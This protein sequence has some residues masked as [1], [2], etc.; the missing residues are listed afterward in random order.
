M[1]ATLG[2][3][4]GCL[5]I[6]SPRFASADTVEKCADASEQADRLAAEHKP[7]AA[8]KALEA[9]VVPECPTAVRQYC[10]QA[11]EN[12]A[13]LVPSVIAAARD[14]A[15]RD[16][17]AVKLL[18]DGAAASLGTSIELEPG[19]HVFRF[20][21]AGFRAKEER[22]NLRE[23]ER[24][25]L[26][27]VVLETTEAPRSTPSA[28]RP[29]QTRESEASVSPLAYVFAGVA[30]VAAGAGTVLGV[31]GQ[32]QFDRCGSDGCTSSEWDDVDRLRILTWVS[33]GVAAT[34]AGV[35]TYLF[36]RPTRSDTTSAHWTGF[37][38]AATASF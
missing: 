12:L 26:L 17:P 24:Q 16:V 30:V 23:S 8:R 20:E 6:L 31:K 15:G 37:H 10:T 29:A 9:C 13:K 11:S 36:L 25:R 34:S 21:A 32:N 2:A 7:Q 27:T 35:S 22:L 5:G 18:V 28:P 3:L 4:L 14:A 1:R 38:V 33:V 19:W